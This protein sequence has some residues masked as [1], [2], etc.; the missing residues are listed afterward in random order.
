M[1]FNK[2]RIYDLAQELKV[3]SKRVI[4]EAR[5]EGIDVS[6][7][8]NTVPDEVASKIRSKIRGDKREDPLNRELNDQEFIALGLF[9]GKIKIVSL[10]PDGTYR[11]V[12][13]GQNLHNILYITSSETLTLQL[14]IEELESLIND[15]KAKEADFQDFFERYPDFILNDEYKKAHPH[16]VLSRSD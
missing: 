1:P 11:F 15:P 4:D 5:L 3:D 9:D 13:D 16:I 2:N 10:S 6:V 14:A 12:D 8:S 7:P